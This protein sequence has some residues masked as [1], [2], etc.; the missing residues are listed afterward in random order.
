MQ[1]C[2]LDSFYLFV[3]SA[4][5]KDVHSDNHFADFTVE[6]PRQI[7]LHTNRVGGNEWSVALTDI[8]I[9]V[10]GNLRSS[11]HP[12]II[13]LCDLVEDSHLSGKHVPLLR[14]LPGDI[15]RGGSLQIAQYMRVNRHTFSRLR[16]RLTDPTLTPIHKDSEHEDNLLACTLHFQRVIV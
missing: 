14:I 7:E 2:E 9:M 5:S 13:A 10:N 3:T 12:T 15:A 11:L 1:H 4:D 8:A 6:L 16:I